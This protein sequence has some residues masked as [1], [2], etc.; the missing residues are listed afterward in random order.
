MSF[1]EYGKKGQAANNS[2][3]ANDAAANKTTRT[4]T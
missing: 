2:I 4:K 1:S 3:V